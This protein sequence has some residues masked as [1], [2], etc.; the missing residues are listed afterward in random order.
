VY[1]PYFS[2]TSRRHA[3]FVLIICTRST[4]SDDKSYQS[5]CTE[6]AEFNDMGMRKLFTQIGGLPATSALES[7]MPPDSRTYPY[8]LLRCTADVDR[9]PQS[10][11]VAQAER[12]APTELRH[13][14]SMPQHDCHGPANRAT[15]FISPCAECNG[16]FDA[17]RF[18]SVALLLSC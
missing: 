2:C 12:C 5:P 10:D 13:A 9:T 1:A 6:W 7:V 15:R 18:K 4:K 17:F 16:G 8:A 3:Q 14:Q 11:R